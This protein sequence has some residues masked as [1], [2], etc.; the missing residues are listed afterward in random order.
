LGIFFAI[1]AAIG[2]KINPPIIIGKA[3][4]HRKFSKPSRIPKVMTLVKL[5]IGSVI[6]TMPIAF[7]G[8]VPFNTYADVQIGPHPPPLL[9]SMN[10]ANN[11]RSGTDR[12][13]R[14]FFR[15]RFRRRNL[16][17]MKAPRIVST[18]LT[19]VFEIDNVVQVMKKA[20]ANAPIM[21]GKVNRR[22]CPR[23][24]LP[25]FQ[26]EIAETKSTTISDV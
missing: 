14:R 12:F 16:V 4:P 18:A 26:C 21:P 7:L 1:N 5:T 20:P 24:K 25:S 11:P 6:S 10:A 15:L 17:R 9:T 2:V 13:E 8:S 23:S 22:K 3:S 19:H